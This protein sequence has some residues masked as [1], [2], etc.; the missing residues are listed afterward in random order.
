MKFQLITIL[1][2]FQVTLSFGQTSLA[3]IDLKQGEF[4]VGFKHYL[5]IDSIRTYKRLYDWNNQNIPRPIRINIWYPSNDQI[6]KANPC[7]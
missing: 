6:K 7:I 5:K 3:K 1:L 2:C 4:Q